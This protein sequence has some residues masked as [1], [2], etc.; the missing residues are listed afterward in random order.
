VTEA[1]DRITGSVIAVEDRITKSVTEVEDRIT[2]STL[3]SFTRVE[4]DL[5]E[6]KLRLGRVEEKLDDMVTPAQH[7]T[8]VKRVEAL[9]DK[10]R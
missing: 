4:A 6:V 1:E 7:R 2:V 9:E 5:S 10:D 8:L 3:N